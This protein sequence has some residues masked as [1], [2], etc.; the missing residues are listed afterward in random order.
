MIKPHIKILSRQ[1]FRWL[2]NGEV[3]RWCY[4]YVSI[5]YVLEMHDLKIIRKIDDDTYFVTGE[6]Q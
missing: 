5:D 3:C 1:P 2:L 4:E 6:L